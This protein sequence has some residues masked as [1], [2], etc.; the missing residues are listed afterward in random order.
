RTSGIVSR[1]RTASATSPCAICRDRNARIGKPIR[2]GRTVGPKSAIT[3]RATSLSSRACTVP[4]ATPSIRASSVRPMR[5]WARMVSRSH[6]GFADPV[7]RARRNAIAAL[8]VG[9]APGEPIPAAEYTPAEHDVWRLVCAEFDVRHRKYA[10]RAYL[11]GKERLGLL[12][13]GV[14]Q[15]QD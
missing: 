1:Y 8:A 2:S 14:P 15:L 3:S 11:D 7:Y 10:V 5:G 13:E 6:P 4:R 12:G 9:H